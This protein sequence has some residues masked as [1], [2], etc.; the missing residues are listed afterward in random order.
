MNRFKRQAIYEKPLKTGWQVNVDERSG[1]RVM[2][3]GL[4]DSEIGVE[5]FV[6]QL[7]MEQ[8]LSLMK[9]LER[10]IGVSNPEFNQSGSSSL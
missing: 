10:E 3:E 8:K 2:Q 9:Q 4:R 1:S 6:K 7:P 5:D